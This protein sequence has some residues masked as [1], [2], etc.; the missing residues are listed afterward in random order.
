MRISVFALFL[1]VFVISGQAQEMSSA[2]Y[3][4]SIETH[5]KE[6][7][8]ALATDEL[9]PIEGKKAIKNMQ[10]YEV[11]PEWKVKCLFIRTYDAKPFEM[12]TFNNEE[13]PYIKYGELLFEIKGKGTQR[14]N[15]YQSLKTL[16]IPAFK[17]VL[18][19]PFTDLTNGE[20]TFKGGRYIDIQ[21]TDT[22]QGIVYLDFNKAYNPWCA[23]GDVDA[24]SCPVPP[25]ENNLNFKILAGEKIYLGEV[26]DMASE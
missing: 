6:Y 19:V 20:S 9:S 11:D 25:A 2:D 7:Q 15:V 23:Y 24:Y 18:F 14:I 4:K 12:T 16:K 17:N 22:Q 1:F 13:K 10:Y 8:K 3:V 26:M 5:R 21:I